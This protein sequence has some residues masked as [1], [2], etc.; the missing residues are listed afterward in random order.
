MRGNVFF[1]AHSVNAHAFSAREENETHLGSS[2]IARNHFTQCQL[3]ALGTAGKSV[4]GHLI[5]PVLGVYV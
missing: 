2:R 4:F 3:Q 1:L 5:A